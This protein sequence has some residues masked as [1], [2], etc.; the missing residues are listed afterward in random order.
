MWRYLKY[1]HIYFISKRSLPDKTS[2][3]QE[4]V[5]SVAIKMAETANPDPRHSL[6]GLHCQQ[7]R[8]DLESRLKN[9]SHVSTI[10]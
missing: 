3:R 5:E 7:R 2:Y 8:E 9:S 4:L 6:L 1:K 10:I